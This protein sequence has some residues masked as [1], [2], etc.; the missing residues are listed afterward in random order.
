MDP[1]Q[2][3]Q[4]WQAHSS[5]T[6]VT[7]NADL[8]LGEVQRSKGQLQETILWRDLREAGVSLVMIPL[9]LFLGITLSLPWTWYLAVPGMIFVAGFILVDRMRHKPKPSEP[10]EPLLVS[11]KNSLAEV[12]HQIWLLRNV[13]W[14]YLLPFAIPI[15]AFFAQVSLQTSTG[16]WQFA[17][18]FGSSSSFVV[19]LYFLIYWL[20]QRAVRVQLEPRRQWLLTLLA[21]LGDESTEQ[22]ATSSSAKCLRK[23]GPFT[24]LLILACLC[25][26]AYYFVTLVI[27]LSGFRSEG[28]GYPRL[29]PFSAVRWQ[30]S[31]PEV[32]IGPRWFRLVALNDIPVEEIIAFSKATYAER[33]QKRFEEDLV[34]LLSRMGHP[35]EDKVKLEVQDLKSSNTKVFENVPMTA[36][37]RQAIKAAADAQAG[38]KE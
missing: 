38:R 27:D 18:S 35:P 36:A 2:L 19:A 28:V 24:R 32:K 17:F 23:A 3:Q 15:L 14:W 12:E 4:A 9:W 10:G 8:L 11:L 34:E 13:L 6:R 29:S 37:N 16:W 22:D 26:V 20:N 7:I 30:E 25:F 33:W 31:Q 5:Q 21:D 1:D